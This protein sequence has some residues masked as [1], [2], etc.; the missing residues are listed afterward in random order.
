MGS[1]GRILVAD[2]EETFLHSTGDLLRREGYTC[3]CVK[4][5]SGARAKLQQGDYDLLIADIKMPGNPELEL[6]EYVRDSAEGLQVILVTGYPSMKSAIKSI[7][8]PVVAYLVKPIDFELLLSHVKVSMNRSQIYHAMRE[9]KRNLLGWLQQLNDVTELATR[10]PGDT[11]LVPVDAYVQ[12]TLTNIVMALSG[13]RNVTEALTRLGGEQA[14]CHLLNCPKSDSL[15]A[16]LK[17]A[18]EIL[19]KSKSAFKSKELGEL[20]HRLEALLESEKS[21]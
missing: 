17:D 20:R 16:A 5:S 8:L 2:D 11:M 6:V 3:D 1:L 19:K 7:D 10:N 13:L 9:S 14:V 18:V 21:N 4:D 15:I 12:L